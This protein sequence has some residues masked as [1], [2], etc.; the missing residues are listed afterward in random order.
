[1]Q[2]EC[3]SLL[4]LAA[5]DEGLAAGIYAPPPKY[6]SAFREFLG[7]PEGVEVAGVITVGHGAP[8]Q[9]PDTSAV[10]HGRVNHWKN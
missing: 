8:E 4:F 6:M 10:R 2:V 7:V 3:A 9:S 5:L 1:M